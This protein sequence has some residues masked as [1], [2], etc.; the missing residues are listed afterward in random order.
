MRPTINETTRQAINRKKN[1][2]GRQNSKPVLLKPLV[3]K[4]KQHH[5]KLRANKSTR[6]L[7]RNRSNRS[8][9]RLGKSTKE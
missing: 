3:K 5:I 8:L 7:L 4:T 9:T 6:I 2:N 1:N